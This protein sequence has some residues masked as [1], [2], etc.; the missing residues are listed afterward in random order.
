MLRI[1]GYL[2]ERKLIRSL[3]DILGEDSVKTQ[4]SLEGSRKRWDAAFSFNN[5][6]FLVD[7]DGDE[8]YRNTIRIKSDMSKDQE[9]R[10]VGFRVVRFPYWIQL[11]STTAE[12]YFGL[13]IEIEQDFPHGF[14]TTK[15]FPASFCELGLSRFEAE[16]D[17]LPESIR[18]EVIESLVDRS[19]DFGVKFV[20]PSRL[21]HFI[22]G[23]Q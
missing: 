9:S 11:D 4:Y 6:D 20:V 22:D 2:T 19:A 21:Q 18:N 12:H 13:N 1:E 5:I 10:I 17:D 7:Y 8:H 23:Y 3:R 16:L 15:I 14:I